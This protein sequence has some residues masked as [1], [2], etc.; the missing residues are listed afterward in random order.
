MKFTGDPFVDV[1]SLVME[2]LSKNKKSVEEQIR[3]ATDVYVDNWKGKLHSIFLHS[4]ITH[5]SLSKKPEKQRG[6]ALEYYVGALQGKGA[7]SKGYC[8]ICAKKGLLF[9]GERKNFPLV[10]S[11]E[12]T[13]FHHFQES[14]LLIC[15]DCLVKLYFLP[16]GVLQSSGKLMFL[17]IQNEYIAKFWKEETILKNL[18]KLSRGSCDEILKTNYKNPKNA[19][20]YFAS[21]LIERFEDLH[22]QKIRVVLFSNFGSKPEIEFHDL[23]NPVFLFLKQVLRPALKTE[24]FY[25]V[26]SHYRFSKKSIDFDEDTG[27]WFETKKKITTKLDEQDYVG[28]NANTI[29][30]CLLFGKS[31]LRH[32]CKVHKKRKFS[33]HIAISYVK[34]VRNMSPEQIELIQNIADKII[35]LSKKAGNYN[36]YI[37]EIEGSKRSYELRGK[38]V[39][40]AKAYYKN[41]ESE[42]F[43]RCK[44]YV[45]YLFADGQSWYETRDLLLICL[46]EKLHDLRVDPN[47]ISENDPSEIDKQEPSSAE[48]FNS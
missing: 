2:E 29:Y 11:G 40:M 4:K 34:E 30:N 42:P 37:A 6:G 35:T 33:I 1:G 9:E 39:R 23:P 47:E 7:V 38:I 13:N 19:L 48:D 24:W 45:E 43:V 10:G 18:D 44:D 27:Q 3:F 28:A 22:L 5:I 25:F 14:G 21:K 17:Q 20:F 8:R 46:Y 26:K 41:E 36:K 12:F 15:K 16:L 31:I 32:L